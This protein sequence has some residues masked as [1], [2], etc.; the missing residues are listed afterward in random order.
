[1]LEERGYGGTTLHLL[2]TGITHHAIEPDDEARCLLEPACAAGDTLPANG[3]VGH[4]FAP[5]AARKGPGADDP[6]SA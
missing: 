2:F 3:Q 5:A 4:D 1:M 6:P